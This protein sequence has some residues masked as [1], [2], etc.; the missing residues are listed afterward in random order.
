MRARYKVNDITRKEGDLSFT[1]PNTPL[2]TG[3]AH[4]RS[5][6]EAHGDAPGIERPIFTG[7]RASDLAQLGTS[8]THPEPGD[9]PVTAFAVFELADHLRSDGPAHGGTVP[10]RTHCKDA[11]GATI[12]CRPV[13]AIGSPMMVPVGVCTC[14][15]AGEYYTYYKLPPP[16]RC[17]SHSHALNYCTTQV[18]RPPR[19]PQLRMRMTSDVHAHPLV[20]SIPARR[21]TA[22]RCR[23]SRRRPH[24]RPGRRAS[25]RTRA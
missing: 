24:R 25:A 2:F 20:C 17:V 3:C 4:L 23:P 19:A 1:N 10:T 11:S 22:H 21:R 15:S 8:F 16:P 9:R 14:R 7:D 12:T 18:P 5:V 13:D 6:A